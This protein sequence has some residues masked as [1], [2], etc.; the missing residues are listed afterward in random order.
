MRYVRTIAA[1]VVALNLFPL[2]HLKYLIVHTPNGEQSV[3]FTNHPPKLRIKR[4]GKPL[5]LQ[6]G[7]FKLVSRGFCTITAQNIEHEKPWQLACW[8][9]ESRPSLDPKIIEK[10]YAFS[11]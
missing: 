8:G 6:Q 5:N 7:G 2:M 10:D 1:T 4:I 3:L 11:L 9:A